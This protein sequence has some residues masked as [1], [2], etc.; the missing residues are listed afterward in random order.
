MT[1][2]V[3]RLFEGFQPEH[4]ELFVAPDAEKM[5][6]SGKVTITGKK[7]GRPSQRLTFHQ[8]GLKIT[9]AK[10]IKHDKKGDQ[11][12]ALSRINLQDTL[13]E[14]RLHSNAMLYP[15]SYTVTM[16]FEGI[17]VK[18]MTGLYPCFYNHKG[19]EKILLATQFESHYAREM[20]PC[21][22]EPEAK[23]TFDLSVTSPITHTVLGN[24]PIKSKADH[25]DSTAT[26]VFETSPRMSTYLLAFVAGE[27]HGKTSK[28]KS[29][30]EVGTWGTV[31]QPKEALDFAL[32]VGVKTVEFFEDYFQVPYPLPKLD[33]IGLPDFAV[34]AMENWGLVTYREAVYYLYPEAASQSVKETISLVVAHETS[35]QW[36]GNLVT[37]KWWDDLWLNESFANMMEY[38]AVDAI[39]PEWHIWESFITA[40]ALQSWR[41]DATPGVQ[42]VKLP[43]HHPDEITTM[44]D[45]SIVYAKGGRLLYMLK[46]YLGE[47]A[48]RKGLQRYF[49]AH[50][51]KNTI[52]ADLWEALGEASGINVADFMNLWLERSGFPVVVVKQTDTSLEL[53]QRH[54]LEDPAKA[55]PERIWPVPL[56]IENSDAPI[57]LDKT[58]A[59]C[60]LT[61][62]DYLLV[63]EDARGHF[64]TH[65]ENPKH[66][67]ALVDQ[68]AKQQP[69]TIDRLTLLNSSSML[70]RAG[71]ES[72]GE[73]LKLL[74][75]Y[76]SET[77]EA[78]W[79]VMSLII[80]DIRRF[81]DQDETLESSI[82]SLVDKLIQT[83]HTRLGWEEKPNESIADQKLRAT[84]LGLGAY[85]DNSE[86]ISKALSLFDKYKKD[87]NSVSAEF[88]G[89]I[90]S[91]AVKTGYEGAFDY[92]LKQYPEVNS[93]LQHD[94]AGGMTATRLASEADKMFG[95]IKDFRYVKPQDA[96]RW[97]FSLLRNR[98]VREHAWKWMEDNWEWIEETY[99]DD[100]SYDYFPRFAAAVT[101]T[102]ELQK[103]FLAFFTPLESNAIL[104]RNILI[105]KEEIE[106]RL[107]WLERDLL[108][109]QEFFEPI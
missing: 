78:V 65:Y 81:V 2:S 42:P 34:G 33:H 51:F 27:I 91:V 105:G 19:K 38:E 63:N 101:N 72:F 22:D 71:Y 86:I 28:T 11:E 43:V 96:N 107:K 3:K 17:I 30:V 62:A 109:V 10:V 23:A 108:S 70:S 46:N 80:A 13:H 32:E 66:R 8:K 29:G 55:D 4:Y 100:K 68:V 44:F 31:A 40:E 85:A 87:P 98:Y 95:V 83:E 77:E 58:N 41:R 61:T 36:F 97:I 9:S 57:I 64:I 37:M 35:H 47:D 21:I 106:N 69:G 26:T 90:L 54:F 82:K 56:F 53:A 102:R 39:F 7:V 93:D 50:A 92:L 14:V 74:D 103:K 75:A 89:I 99:D 52:G 84:I 76:S 104:G 48:F 5:N 79:D 94:I 16:E 1:K 60:E 24:T 25:K 45:P 88:R 49:Q 67:Q 18:N 12:V 15:G 20:F 6:F 73:T 59:T